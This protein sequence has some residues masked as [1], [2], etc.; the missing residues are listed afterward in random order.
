MR[1]ISFAILFPL[2]L[3]PLGSNPQRREDKYQKTAAA[4]PAVSSLFAV[5]KYL[6]ATQDQLS[7][8]LTSEMA[9]CCYRISW[10][11][12]H[13]TC[14]RCG[15]GSTGARG[16]EYGDH[17]GLLLARPILSEHLKDGV[18]LPQEIR[19]ITKTKMIGAMDRS[20]V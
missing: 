13:Q 17:P 16:T 15:S 11:A 18:C 14:M 9:H 1:I 6:N 10:L 12:R 4:F 19:N 7:R 2:K 5:M 3:L 20:G 8:Q